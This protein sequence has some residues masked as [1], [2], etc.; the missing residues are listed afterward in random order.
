MSVADTVSSAPVG[1]DDIKALEV[2]RRGLQRTPSVKR[3]M[4]FSG[5]VSVL[6]AVGRLAVPV[7]VQQ[8]ID[9]GLLGDD[10]YRPRLV[11]VLSMLALALV[12]VVAVLAPLAEIALV[13]GAQNAIY[14]LRRQAFAHIHRLSLAEQ[15]MEKKGVLLARVTSDI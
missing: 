12:V 13:R 10:G 6:T 2:L 8:V 15:N 3:T 1:N 9:R 5:L 11:M 14:D 7:L 4:V